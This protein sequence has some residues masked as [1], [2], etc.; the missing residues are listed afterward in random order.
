M[1]ALAG[2]FHPIG[3][4]EPVPTANLDDYQ[5][6]VAP[7]FAKSCV[8]CHGPKE[9]KAGLRVDKLD[10]NLLTGGDVDRWVEIYDVLSQREMPP[11]DESDY[12]LRWAPESGP[13]AKL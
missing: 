5:K 6:V 4:A 7:L 8:D 3:A 11:D 10:P 9:S 12:H 1:I 13:G 2:W